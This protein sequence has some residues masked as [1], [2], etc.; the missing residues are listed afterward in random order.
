MYDVEVEAVCKKIVDDLLR[1]IIGGYTVKYDEILI[2]HV[3][4]Q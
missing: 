4:G 3:T 2:D 1:D